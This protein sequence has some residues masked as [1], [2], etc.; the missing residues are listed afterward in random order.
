MVEKQE[1]PNMMETEDANA[2]QQQKPKY[3]KKSEKRNDE[4]E[5]KGEDTR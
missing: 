5:N 4:E 3:R 2:P 1:N